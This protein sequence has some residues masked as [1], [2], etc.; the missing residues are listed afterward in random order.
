MPVSSRG[1]EPVENNVLNG[2]PSMQKNRSG[3]TLVE[4][5]V[6]VACLAILSAVVAPNWIAATWPAYRLKNAARQIVSD[7]RYARMRSISTNRQY[8]LRI[9]PSTDSYF[10]ERGDAS[11]GSSSWSIEGS[12][13]RFGKLG[14]ESFSGIGIEG[15]AEYRIICQPTG[16]I[17]S[18]TTTLR[19]SLGRTTKIICSMA[20]RIRM[21]R[22]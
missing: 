16:G 1:I 7:I 22:E 9:D 5:M 4:L 17:T 14:S 15:K 20:G 21:V 10:M 3:F 13:R 6:V 2:R 12:T 11:T 19:N 18:A 8:R